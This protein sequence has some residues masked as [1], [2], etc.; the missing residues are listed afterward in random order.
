MKRTIPQAP[1]TFG[2]T[3]T[4]RD[5]SVLNIM[6]DASPLYRNGF[7]AAAPNL[8]ARGKFLS[9]PRNRRDVPSVK[10]YFTDFG[11]STRFDP[12]SKDHLVTGNDCQDRQLPEIHQDGPYDPFLADVF[13]LG[14][15]YKHCFVKVSNLLFLS[16]P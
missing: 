3:K 4:H 16:T 11:I 1:Y 14:N 13:I 5:C 6:M 2:L 8:D 15:L 10:Y 12:S 9:N 7:H